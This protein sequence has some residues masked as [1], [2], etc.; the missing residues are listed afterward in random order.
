VSRDEKLVKR[1]LLR[2]NISVDD[3]DRLLTIYGYK[4]HKSSSSHRVY[5]QKGATPIT[6]V[7]PKNSKYVKPGYINLI[8]KKLKL[9][10]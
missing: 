1:F 7:T 4:L 8:I 5:H 9:E 2:K 10:D 3:C 6:V